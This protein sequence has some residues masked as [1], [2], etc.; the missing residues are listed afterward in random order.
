MIQSSEDLEGFLHKLERPV[1]RAAP[2]TF[3]LR[4]EAGGALVALHL[5]PPLLVVRAE[6]GRIP[7]SAESSSSLFKKL[8]ELNASSLVHAAYGIEGEQIVLAS[9]L[10]LASVDLNELEGV[11]SDVDLALA[12]HV[13]LLHEMVKS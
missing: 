4:M 7:S 5:Q 11:L 1:E 3:V 6:I 8:L 12:E 2:G 10:E 13:P 9:A